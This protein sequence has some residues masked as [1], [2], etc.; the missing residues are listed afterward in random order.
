MTDELDPQ[1]QQHID[2]SADAIDGCDTST[3][4]NGDIDDATEEMPVTVDETADANVT[5]EQDEEEQSEQPDSS[6]TESKA[7]SAPQAAG[8]IE[9]SSEE[10][11]DAVMDPAL[12]T[13]SLIHI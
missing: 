13:L 2:D 11:L 12:Y 6:E 3:S 10:E 4:S 5:A 8:P 7:D 1:T 9:V